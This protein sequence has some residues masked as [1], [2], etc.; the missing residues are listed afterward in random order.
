MTR[1]VKL[2]DSEV[3]SRFWAKVVA[4]RSGCW[5]W[6]AGV[7]KSGYGIFKFKGKSL[8]AHRVAFELTNGRI[9]AVPGYHGTVVRHTC[10][11]RL[12][13]NPA[14][15]KLGTVGD[16]NRDTVNDG[17]HANQYYAQNHP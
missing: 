11:N 8:S 12:C 2:S 1:G 9:K 6:T 14:H 3:G 7:G 13:V 15:L 10:R 17:Q 5:H 4:V 16:N